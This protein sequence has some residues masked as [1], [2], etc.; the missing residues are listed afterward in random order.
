MFTARS[1]AGGDAMVTGADVLRFHGPTLPGLE[2]SIVGSASVQWV[3]WEVLPLT[4]EKKQST[5]EI[6]QKNH[7]FSITCG[8]RTVSAQSGGL[9]NTGL[10]ETKI[11]RAAI[12]AVRSFSQ[13]SLQILGILGAQNSRRELCPR[14]KWRRR[15]CW[16]PTLFC[17]C[18][19]VCKENLNFWTCDQVR[20]FVRP[21]CAADKGRWPGW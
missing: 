19:S 5:A 7:L 15:R 6:R 12:P 18:R 21:V 2:H 3:G 14:A 17:G 9:E 13:R 8:R 1:S 16:Q 10:R 4:R 11:G 20:T